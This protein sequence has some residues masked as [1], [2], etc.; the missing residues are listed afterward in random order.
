MLLR[1]RPIKSQEVHHYC[2]VQTG[3]WIISTHC[4]PQC[5]ALNTS[6]SLSSYLV[7]FVHVVYVSG[8]I[9][10]QMASFGRDNVREL[11][12][13]STMPFCWGY[14][15][16]HFK[17]NLLLCSSECFQGKQ[18]KPLRNKC[19]N[20]KHVSARHS[21]GRH[22][23]AKGQMDT[24]NRDGRRREAKK[25]SKEGL[26]TGA[27][28]LLGR[29]EIGRKRGKASLTGIAKDKSTHCHTRST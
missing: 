5:T 13:E 28:K 20:F 21:S 19:S 26:P 14:D 1:S 22:E 17:S 23:M 6:L 11:L 18:T 9:I 29:K 7:L 2:P 3:S 25:R 15:S 8:P 12:T 10:L 16:C 4:V 24:E 27:E